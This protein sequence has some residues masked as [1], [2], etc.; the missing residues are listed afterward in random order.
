M[1]TVRT[2]QFFCH[3]PIMASMRAFVLKGVQ[4]CAI[5]I[6]RIGAKTGSRIRACLQ[7]R[8]ILVHYETRFTCLYFGSSD[9]HI[10]SA[11]ACSVC[12]AHTEYWHPCWASSAHSIR[13]IL[14]ASLKASPDNRLQ[15]AWASLDCRRAG[16][17]CQRV[18]C[19]GARDDGCRLGHKRGG[20]PSAGRRADTGLRKRL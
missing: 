8:F 3:E 15:Y 14:L 9:K 18:E 10:S 20:E 13:H 19:G 7:S 2:A 11:I 4:L 5:M 16:R 17:L 6:N 12:P 1:T